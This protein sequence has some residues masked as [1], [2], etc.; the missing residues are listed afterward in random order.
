MK[1]VTAADIPIDKFHQAESLAS[2]DAT[3]NAHH[4]EDTV[5]ELHT[6]LQFPSLFI[7][8]NVAT[9]ILLSVSASTLNLHLLSLLHHPM[10]PQLAGMSAIECPPTRIEWHPS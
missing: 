6:F 1:K 8:H 4:H 3:K 5:V 2:I 10:D 7:H 9:W